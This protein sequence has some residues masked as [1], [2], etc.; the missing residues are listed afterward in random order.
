MKFRDIEWIFVASE[1]NNNTNNKKISNVLVLTRDDNYKEYLNKLRKEIINKLDEI[2]DLFPTRI[3][4][5]DY[6]DIEIC[7]IK[8]QENFL[9]DMNELIAKF[10]NKLSKLCDENSYLYTLHKNITLEKIKLKSSEIKICENISVLE[11]NSNEE[12]KLKIKDEVL[13]NNSEMNLINKNG[14]KDL[15]IFKDGQTLIIPFVFKETLINRT[16]KNIEWKFIYCN[17]NPISF[18]YC[19]NKVFVLVRNNEK[20]DIIDLKESIINSIKDDIDEFYFKYISIYIFNEDKFKSIE[21]IEKENYYIENYNN[22]NLENKYYDKI[23]LVEEEIYEKIPKETE[24]IID[25]LTLK[26]DNFK[27][28]IETNLKSCFELMNEDNLYSRNKADYI[29]SSI[30]WYTLKKWVETFENEVYENEKDLKQNL[31]NCKIKLRCVEN[32]LDILE[33]ELFFDTTCTNYFGYK[34]LI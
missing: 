9:K 27:E 23:Q 10:D 1:E 26:N 15:N 13:K 34:N 21:E 31:L 14:V 32:Y 7:F 28:K 29:L 3:N 19:F 30:R 2:K 17:T 20:Y 12:V 22:W 8:D 25:D 11:N 5:K 16:F 33:S 18:G 6:S 24:N 4:K